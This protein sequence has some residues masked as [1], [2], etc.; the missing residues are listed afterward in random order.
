MDRTHAKNAIRKRP[1]PDPGL[2]PTKKEKSRATEED[3]ERR[4]K[5]FVCWLVA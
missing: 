4:L 2:E 1:P 5:A 3:L